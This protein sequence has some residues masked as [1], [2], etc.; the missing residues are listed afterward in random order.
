M[1][2]VKIGVF[3]AGRGETMMSYCLHAQ[4]AKLVAVC[5]KN[6]ALLNQICKKDEYK[7]VTF[8]H[9]FE[10]FLKHDMDAVVLAN[11]ATE[12]AP[13]AVR[14]LEAGFHVLSEVLPCETLAE[15]VRLVET[16]EKTHKIYAY[17][18]NYCFMPAPME[19][20][21]L[22]QAGKLGTFEYGEGEYMHNCEPIWADL[23][24]NDPMHWRNTMSAA[25]YCTHSIGPLLHITGL[26]P[27]WVSVFELPHNARCDRMN[28]KGGLAAVE[29]IT[30]E[31]GAVIKSVHG[32]GIARNSIWYSI[33]GSLGRMESAREDT[34]QNDVG[35][36]YLNLDEKEGENLEKVITY[37]PEDSL[38]AEAK[39]Y[40]HGGSDYYTMWN[41]VEKIL[42]N[43]DADTIDI[44]EALNMGLPGVLA[45]R[46]IQNHNIAVEIPDLRDKAQRNLYRND[47]ACTNPEKAG[48]MLIPSLIGG[49]T[50]RNLSPCSNLCNN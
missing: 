42:G 27:K 44:Y 13:Y 33:Y 28:M 30:L 38:S 34:A 4:N 35:R 8:Y 9:D 11:Y 16:A 29:I 12:H 20:R 1:D 47:T 25:F 24:R 17:A 49:N 2:K 5:D 14:C 41:F 50:A 3:G 32:C 36:I 39:A 46:S 19:M 43:P 21:R 18:E 23:S 26:R 40:G 6:D 48:K 22:Y 37:E 7:N 45:Y 10:D 31:N 15:A